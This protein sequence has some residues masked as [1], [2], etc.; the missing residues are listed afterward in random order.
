MTAETAVD[1]AAVAGNLVTLRTAPV[2]D[3][4]RAAQAVA[5]LLAALGYPAEGEHRAK[6]P[7]RVANALAG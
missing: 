2:A 6:T 7:Q 1:E 5:D 4:D 3:L